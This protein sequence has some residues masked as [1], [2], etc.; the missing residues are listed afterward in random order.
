MDAQGQTKLAFEIETDSEPVSG[1]LFVWGTEQ[2][3]APEFPISEI[4]FPE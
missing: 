4:L 1:K 3:L 2:E